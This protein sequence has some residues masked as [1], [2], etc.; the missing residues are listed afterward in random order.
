MES[1]GNAED[2]AQGRRL[3]PPLASWILCPFVSLPNGWNSIIPFSVIGWSFER[4]SN[5]ADSSA[6][7]FCETSRIR[8][9]ILRCVSIWT[10]DVCRTLELASG[11]RWDQWRYPRREHGSLSIQVKT[12][13]SGPLDT[14]QH[15]EEG[16]S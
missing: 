4:S 5:T 1:A 14:I 15:Q 8:F 6:Y 16:K 3:N 12:M 7:G 9:M 13:G 10:Q 11:V 2:D